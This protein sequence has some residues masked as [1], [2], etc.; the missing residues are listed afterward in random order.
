MLAVGFAGAADTVAQGVCFTD[1]EAKKAIELIMASPPEPITSPDKTLRKKLLAMRDDYAELRIKVTG[2]DPQKLT[3]SIPELDRVGERNLLRVCQMVKENGWLTKAVL[4]EDGAD[5]LVFLISENNAY[6]LQR[7]FLPVLNE[8]ARKGYVRYRLVA[9]MVDS[10][11]VGFGLPQV[12]GTQAAIRDNVIYLFPLLNEARTDAWRKIYD[13]PPL[14]VQINTLEARY[15][16]L[17]MRWKQ[18]GTAILPSFQF[19]LP[20]PGAAILRDM[21]GNCSDRCRCLPM[22]PVARCMSPKI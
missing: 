13:L 15:G 17:P 4:G 14:A 6:E 22:R 21:H 5:A 12:F 18:S 10:I 9:A 1:Q 16:P 8:A 20:G 3:G 19:A 11:R 2:G 7:Q